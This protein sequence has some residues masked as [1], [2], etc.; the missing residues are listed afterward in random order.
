M[1]KEIRLINNLIGAAVLHGS[2]SGGSYEQAEE[3]IKE[4]MNDY[5]KFKGWE[6]KYDIDVDGT[7][8]YKNIIPWPAPQFIE[9]ERDIWPAE[10][11]KKNL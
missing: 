6:D 7:Y 4:K 8:L 3:E 1:D 11:T 2:D 10:V 9:K 5:L